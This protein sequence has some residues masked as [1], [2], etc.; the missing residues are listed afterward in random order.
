MYIRARRIVR[1][2]FVVEPHRLLACGRLIVVSIVKRNNRRRNSVASLPQAIVLL[3]FGKFSILCSM[4]IVL[5]GI[6][7]S[8]KGTQARKLAEEFGYILFETGGA[9]RA[10]AATDSDLGRQV[11]GIINSG[12]H[13]SP[14]IVM[15]VVKAAVKGCP[16]DRPI[17]F[18]GIPRNMDQM[19][20]FDKVLREAGREFRC[21]EIL[22][23]EE[24]AVK[25]ILKRAEIEGR[26][27]DASE[28]SIR[29]R[30]QLF[31]EKTEPVIE[32][33]RSRGIVSDVKGEGD[34]EKV[35]KRLKKAIEN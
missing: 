26:A 14:E 24:A 8:G 5:F 15:D 28:E 6:Q 27:D 18:D 11:K 17:I 1:V 25:R 13:V 33:Y 2:V 4:D 35:Y 22:V 19:E 16:K 23:D 3:H 30:M 20:P 31:H 12:H 29:R 10:I 7:G 34:V 32:V 9:L 21:I